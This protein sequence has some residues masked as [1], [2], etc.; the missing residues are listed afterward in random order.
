MI[1]EPP[2]TSTER[3]LP[4]RGFSEACGGHAA[5][6]IAFDHTNVHASFAQVFLFFPAARDSS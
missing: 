5:M 3:F 2:S 6:V 1:L 4:G